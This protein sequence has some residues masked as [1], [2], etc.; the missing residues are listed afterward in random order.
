[1]VME[2]NPFAI[3]QDLLVDDG[4]NGDNNDDG[5][6]DDDDVVVHAHRPASMFIVYPCITTSIW[7]SSSW[8][9]IRGSA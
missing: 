5:D 4:D 6:D 3:A 1:M 7:L 8:V 2:D 9:R